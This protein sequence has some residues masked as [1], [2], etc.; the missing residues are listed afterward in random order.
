MA[1]FKVGDRVRSIAHMSVTEGCV[2]YVTSVYD[3]EHYN[4]QVDYGV[5]KVPEE[6]S[7]DDWWMKEDE[8]EL[9]T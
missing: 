4:I 2:G 9:V 6:D 7:G 3:T 1:K 8:L 5:G